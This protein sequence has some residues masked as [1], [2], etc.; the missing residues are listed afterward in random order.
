MTSSVPT[1]LVTAAI[2]VR[3]SNVLVTRRKPGT[4]L[5]GVWEFPGGKLEPN[6]DPRD[7]LA[8]ELKEELGIDAFI[9]PVFDVIFHRYP[10]RAVLLLFYRAEPTAKSPSPRPLDVA[11]LR[12]ADVAELD[13]LPMPPADVYVLGKLKAL[14]RRQSARPRTTNR[15]VRH[16]KPKR[17]A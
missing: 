10:E 12:W 7:G 13:H 11:D 5:E 15:R 16:A 9:G 14:L 8:R 17:G 1:L 2:I 4:H 3:G 6:E